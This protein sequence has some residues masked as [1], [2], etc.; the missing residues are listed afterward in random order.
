MIITL[1]DKTHCT[2]SLDGVMIANVT[3]S[4]YPQWHTG[5]PH[6]QLPST[7]RRTPLLFILKGPKNIEG[8]NWR[9]GGEG[10]FTN[11]NRVWPCSKYMRMSRQTRSTRGGS[12]RFLY[13]MAT[14]EARENLLPPTV[15]Y[16][17]ST[18]I[19]IT[20]GSLSGSFGLGLYILWINDSPIVCKCKYSE[21]LFH[22]KTSCLMQHE[23][24]QYLKA[25]LFKILDVLVATRMLPIFKSNTV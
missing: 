23:C 18:L 14:W 16:P 5:V 1:V 3:H 13:C 20:I 12:S 15:Y 22:F 7:N 21:K 4:P 19:F 25:K 11:V 9:S 10:K 17:G 6:L 2:N 24:F 8:R